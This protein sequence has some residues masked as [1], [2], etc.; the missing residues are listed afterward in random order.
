MAGFHRLARGEFVDVVG[1]CTRPVQAFL[2]AV[3]FSPDSREGQIN[4]SN[5][6]SDIEPT[7][8]AYAAA[9]LGLKP[10]ADKRLAMTRRVV[11][12]ERDCVDAESKEIDEEKI[13]GVHFV[14][15]R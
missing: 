11:I 4:L 6:S 9:I 13:S 5:D 8:V 10:W 12:T 15:S 7:G 2:D 3:A 14:S 1:T